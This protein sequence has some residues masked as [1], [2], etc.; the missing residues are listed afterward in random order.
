MLG[1]S[2]AIH[3][4]QGLH[5]GQ[6]LTTANSFAAPRPCGKLPANTSQ[7][8][9]FRSKPLNP[10]RSRHISLREKLAISPVEANIPERNHAAHVIRESTER[11]RELAGTTPGIANELARIARELEGAADALEQAYQRDM[12]NAK[13]P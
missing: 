12:A 8:S 13:K 11:M 5:V 9:P 3:L 1:G 10:P 4:G 2:A 6:T 7:T